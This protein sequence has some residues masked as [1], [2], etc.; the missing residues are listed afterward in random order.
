MSDGG[1]PLPAAPCHSSFLFKALS[2][3]AV[4]GFGA[5]MPSISW[6][7]HRLDLGTL[8]G[9]SGPASPS[10]AMESITDFSLE[11][12]HYTKPNTATKDITTRPGRPDSGL[13]SKD[14]GLDMEP[15]LSS[16]E[17]LSV[18]CSPTSCVWWS[19]GWPQNSQIALK[20][21]TKARVPLRGFTAISARRW[22]GRRRRIRADV[23]EGTTSETTQRHLNLG[24][25]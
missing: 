9:T 2:S 8:Q 19:D 12:N 15:P 22:R 21:L 16:R 24:P 14:L 7:R 1:P 6:H 20:P 18:L 4:C 10:A 17:H 5:T 13:P 23:A 11:V 25:K 3:S